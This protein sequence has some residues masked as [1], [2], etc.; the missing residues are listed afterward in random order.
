MVM[1]E[2]THSASPCSA[3]LA[4]R[5]HLAAELR[6]A[7]RRIAWCGPDIGVD[8]V[9]TKEFAHRLVQQLASRV[10]ENAAHP[11][12]GPAYGAVDDCGDTDQFVVEH[13][14]LLTVRALE[15]VPFAAQRGE[16]TRQ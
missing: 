4:H 14:R 6:L 11:R 5:V 1:S 16:L 15:T 13:G 8:F 10:S 3:V 12:V 9:V 2:M 7:A